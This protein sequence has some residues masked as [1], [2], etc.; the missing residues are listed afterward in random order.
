VP[1]REHV[2]LPPP[3]EKV[4]GNVVAYFCTPDLKILHAAWAPLAAEQFLS[5]AKWAVEL[6]EKLRPTEA[7]ERVAIARAAH[8]ANPYRTFHQSY[9]ADQGFEHTARYDRLLEKVLSPLDQSATELFKQLV[10][11]VASDEEVRVD[12]G[13]DPVSSYGNARKPI[14]SSRRRP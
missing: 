2:N 10:N 11:E 1:I 7:E 8:L 14:P 4:G 9:W 3:P 12:R 13:F 5:Q 6:S